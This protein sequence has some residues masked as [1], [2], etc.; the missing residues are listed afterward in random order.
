MKMR[1]LILL[2]TALVPFG[3]SFIPTLYVLL[4]YY[5]GF[6]YPVSAFCGLMWTTLFCIIYFRAEQGDRRKLRWFA[7]LA[8]FAFIVPVHLILRALGVPPF[9]PSNFTPG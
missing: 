3:V 4:V 7:P 6:T 1:A 2:V 5:F 8:M 9:L